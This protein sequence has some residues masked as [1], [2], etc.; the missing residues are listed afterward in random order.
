M[1]ESDKPRVQPRLPPCEFIGTMDGP[2]AGYG[3]AD[4]GPSE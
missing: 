2:A 1:T 4:S 3:A